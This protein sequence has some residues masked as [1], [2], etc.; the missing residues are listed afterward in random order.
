M[1]KT[2]D[3]LLTNAIVLSMDEDLTQFDPGAV[4][5]SGDSILAIGP[6]SE[7]VNSVEAQETIDCEGKLVMPGLIN[8]HTHVPMTLLRGLA[9][10]L[11]LDVWLMGYMMPVE[12]EY[13]SPDFVR[14]GTQIACVEMIR[15]G[16]TCFADMYY[17]E[18]QVARATSEAGLRA[19]CS[20]TVL[21]FQTPDAQS[22]EESLAEA[23]EFIQ[24]WK[25]H[26]LI[27]PSVAPHSPYTCTEDILRAS[28]ELAV[29]YDVPLHTHLAE[30]ELEAENSRNDHGMPVVP[31]VKKNNI[32]DAK[33]LAAHCVH[34]D[35]GEMHTL[36]H[37]NA[38]VAHCPSSNLKLASGAAPVSK[39]LELGLNVG[40]GTDGPASNNDLDMFEE[41]RL[42]AFLAK[43]IT[44]DPTT[45][46]A[47][48]AITMATRSGAKAIHMEDM[49]GTLEPGK[50]ADL[51]VVDISPLHNSPRFRRD[52]VNVYSQLTYATKSTDVKS[53]MVNGRWLMRDRELL[54]MEQADLIVQAD[55]YAHRIDSFLVER[56]K[57]VLSKLVA[58]GGT[59][60]S[61]S[62]EVQIKV[63]IDDP[64]PVLDAIQ[65]TGLEILYSRHYH[66]Y[67]V[68]FQFTDPTQGVLRYREDEYI[69]DNDEITNVRY[70]LTMI[71]PTREHQFESDVLLSRSR[72]IAPAIHSQR[73]Y[74]EYFN[75][76][77]EVVIEKHRL[78]WRVL[79][80][81]T[82]FYINLDRVDDPPLGHF[83]EVKSRTWSRKDA[84]HKALLARDLMNYLSAS[85]PETLTQDYVEIVTKP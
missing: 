80:Q 42:T 48:T 19:V 57:S 11:R 4:A 21:K 60:E 50:R 66:E 5:I 59:T 75:P 49:I 20:Q 63:R 67:D 32:F 71:G 18:E 17:F 70:R 72:Y 81:G 76:T 15:N 79:F 78:R 27:V 46:P 25:D 68:Y 61:E 1:T 2:A 23:R 35:E 10:D 52:E 6:Q 77:S 34:I 44:G 3:F 28:A 43:G 39:M 29:E 16:V 13:V 38:G 37:H 26:P 47:H 8:A 84:E 55:D 69:D 14:L 40:I 62:F 85:A 31:Y 41:I 83:L 33:V 12:R 7:I 65:G 73:F 51:I 58:I 9:D 56:E 54:T 30:T 22:Y 36:H 74:R 53:V 82:E 24:R 64:V 45:L